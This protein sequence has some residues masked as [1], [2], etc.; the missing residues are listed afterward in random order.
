MSENMAVIK[1]GVRIKI[2]DLEDKDYYI[3]EPY[4]CLDKKL[5]LLLSNKSGE[6]MEISEKNLYDIIHKY[7]TQ[8]F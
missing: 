2:H 4:E 6:G 8:E 3:I 5:N 7:F 1:I